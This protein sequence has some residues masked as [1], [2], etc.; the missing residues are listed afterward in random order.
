M[1]LPLNGRHSKNSSL[2]PLY[3]KSSGA[4]LTGHTVPPLATT[5][6]ETPTMPDVYTIAIEDS[7]VLEVAALILD[8]CPGKCYEMSDEQVASISARCGSRITR[9]AL[10]EAR[11]I[12]GA[13]GGYVRGHPLFGKP[14]QLDPDLF[15]AA[16]AELDP[17]G[18]LDAVIC[19]AC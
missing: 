16:R 17:E 13:V 4:R 7:L 5:N 1:S 19:A 18:R 10:R 14:I 12:P 9:R 3:P 6:E 15:A 2:A 11:F 8:N